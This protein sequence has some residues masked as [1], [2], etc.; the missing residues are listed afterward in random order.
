MSQR[1]SN[2]L[3]FFAVNETL[4]DMLE[5]SDDEEETNGIVNKV[6]DEIGIEISGKVCPIVIRRNC[7]Y[8]FH[9]I[10]HFP[11]FQ[12][13][14]A[15]SAVNDSLGASKFS[16]KEIEAQLAKLRSTWKIEISVPGGIPV[17]LSNN[18]WLHF[19]RLIII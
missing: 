9:W 7:S 8:P 11:Y 12:M 18:Q 10:P 4:D 17:F 19:H 13:S 15:P 14:D 1:Q 6:L 3:N 2:D 5:D 16:E